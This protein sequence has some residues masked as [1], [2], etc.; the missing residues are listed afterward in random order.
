[1]FLAVPEHGIEDRNGDGDTEDLVLAYWDARTR[2]EHD[3]ERAVRAWDDEIVQFGVDGALLAVAIPE[4]DQ[5]VDENGDGDLGDILIEI[6]DL[7]AGTVLATDLPAGHVT[8]DGGLVGLIVPEISHSD[9]VGVD[10][11][12]DGDALDSV[13]DR[14]SVV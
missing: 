11:N 6:R 14:K 1:M 10:R 8:G 7:E 12:G 4:D 2:T 13:A 3:L 9:L 5:G